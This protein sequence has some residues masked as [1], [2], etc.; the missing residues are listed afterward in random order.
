MIR[1]EPLQRPVN[2]LPSLLIA[3]LTGF[4]RQEERIPVSLHP[5]A[6]AQFRLTVA[7]RGVDVVDAVAQQQIERAVGFRLS[8]FGHRIRAED[9]AGAQVAGAAEGRLGDHRCYSSKPSCF[10]I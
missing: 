2:P 9:D 8:A 6:D 1:L 10:R 4:G 5:R 3:P 7:E